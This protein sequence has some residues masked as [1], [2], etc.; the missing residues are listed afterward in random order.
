MIQID[1]TIIS[2][3]FIKS[4][5]KC[6]LEKCKGACCIHGDSGAPL[7]ESEAILLEKIYDKVIPFMREEGI[8]SIKKNG[9]VHMVDSDGD[10][11]TILVDNKECAFVYFENGIAR[12]SIEKA[13]FEKKINFRKPISCFLYPAR[14]KKYKDFKAVNYDKWEICHPAIK[15][16][17]ESDMPLYVFLKDSF[18]SKFGEEWYKQL[19]YVADEIKKED[20]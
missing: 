13:F 18:I 3:D 11:V 15:N 2:I 17:E 10:T 16:G 8:E 20:R 12:C 9:N 19:A 7:E 6:D 1:D 14:V 5:F 4:R